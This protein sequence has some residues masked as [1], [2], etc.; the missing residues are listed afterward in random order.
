MQ[1]IKEKVAHCKETLKS[2]GIEI[3]K[4]NRL[5][6]DSNL[7]AV[8]TDLINDGNSIE[9][10]AKALYKRKKGYRGYQYIDVVRLLDMRRPQGTGLEEYYGKRGFTVSDENLYM[11]ASGVDS[12]ID[13]LYQIFLFEN[14]ETRFHY[15][16]TIRYNNQTQNEPMG[17]IQSILVEAK[18]DD[19]ERKVFLPIT[20]GLLDFKGLLSLGIKA[21]EMLSFVVSFIMNERSANTELL[22]QKVK[23]IIDNDNAYMGSADELEVY[24]QI[25]AIIK[26]CLS[27]S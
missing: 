26:S 15:I 19:G 5:F 18:M 11:I 8:L 27:W 14:K 10:L 2:N 3:D 20:E 13:N 4:L 24:R 22:E 21:P 25:D 12:L 17:P 16:I 9:V 23:K 7:K 1:T 6:S